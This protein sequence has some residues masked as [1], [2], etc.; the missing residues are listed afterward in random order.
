M[1]PFFLKI[2]N[3]VF[4]QFHLRNSQIQFAWIV[5]DSTN[6]LYSQN[7]VY[8][9]YTKL[10]I[11]RRRSSQNYANTIKKITTIGLYVQCITDHIII[12]ILVWCPCLSRTLLTWR[13]PDPAATLVPAEETGLSGRHSWWEESGG[14]RVASHCHAEGE[15]H[16]R[17]GV[18]L[19]IRECF[20]TGLLI[21]KC[22][23]TGLLIRECF[24]TGLNAKNNND[25]K[26]SS[27]YN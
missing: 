26:Y 1:A 16:N 5:M 20:P 25:N 4:L 22:F 6:T 7:F 27:S 13:V 12:T 14:C 3:F 24:P 10:V 9:Y 15:K 8:K 19:L 17:G 21:R 18:R 23:P 2:H 11:K